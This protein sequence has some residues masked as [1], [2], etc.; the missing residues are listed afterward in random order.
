M[1]PAPQP[2]AEAPHFCPVLREQYD[3]MDDM[4]K[5]ATADRPFFRACEVGQPATQL[6]EC[7]E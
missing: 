2:P 6:S 1:T 3:A 5:F 7:A 4:G